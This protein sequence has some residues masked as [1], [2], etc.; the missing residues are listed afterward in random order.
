MSDDA[1]A[2]EESVST[3]GPS[4]SHPG[5]GSLG[6]QFYRG[7]FEH[8]PDPVVV[9]H[10]ETGTIVEANS[11][12]ATL[13]GVDR[14]ELVGSDAMAFS[15]SDEIDQHEELFERFGHTN[16]ESAAAVSVDGGFHLEDA[17]GESIPVE[18]S[19]RSFESGGDRYVVGVFRDLRE[20][21]RRDR[22]L[23]RLHEAT[24]DLLGA[25]SAAS[26]YAIASRTA[27]DILGLPLH[28]FLRYDDASDRL[29]PAAV[30]EQSREL[31]PDVD[32]FDRGEGVFWRVFESGDPVVA[33][34][35]REESDVFNPD[36]PVRSECIIPIGE[37]GLFVA[38]STERDDFDAIDV[39]LAKVLAANTEEALERTARERQL[40]ERARQLRAVV[41]NVPMVLFAFD[42]EGT[43]TLTEGRALEQLGS[44]PGENVGN[45]V[46]D[47]F[48]DHEEIRANCRQALAGESVR[49]TV[50]VATL[51][52]E[53]WYRPILEDGEVQ[54][55]IGTAV[56]V[57]QRDRR[58]RLLRVLNRFLRHNL[59][60]AITVIL[61]NA[62]T[63]AD[64]DDPAVRDA[65][66]E[67]IDAG[68]RLDRLTTK[69]RRLIHLIDIEENPATA[70]L[71]DAL[72]W[73]VQDVE[74][75]REVSVVASLPDASVAIEEFVI[76]VG[77][78]ELFENAVEHGS[79]PVELAASVTD[80]ETAR[81]VIA[82]EGPGLPEHDRSVLTGADETPLN[83]GSGL[84]LF[85]ANWVVSHAGGDIEIEET[86][87]DGTT[88]VI[89]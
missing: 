59:R 15:P 42:D 33:G 78:H 14:G 5:S 50:S 58:E 67:V 26:V 88:I 82:D 37:F 75:S 80:D 86:G 2:D 83:H 76:R 57:T 51:A 22:T 62:E 20:R 89:S 39:S 44:A 13:L 4:E 63:T 41:E 43:L 47:V 53:T 81:I 8:A 72:R 40:R 17:D 71:D 69:A 28:M 10:V 23:E 73:M 56:D 24:R 45:S 61:G 46:F 52:F 6:E 12:A 60:N 74:R 19:A 21:E 27:A 7:L 3:S 79:T 36:T 85:V 18:V 66:E 55:V 70:P 9:A 54:Q 38:S 84:G 77:V 30:S 87:P 29:E 65:A 25:D 64:H 48:P 32:G 31:F 34:D 16:A 11:S 35:I 68:M 1:A 49:S